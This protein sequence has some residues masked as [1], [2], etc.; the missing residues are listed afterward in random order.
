MEVTRLNFLKLMPQILE[1]IQSSTFVAYDMEH[2]GIYADKRLQNTAMDT[3]LHRYM[4][5]RES[6]RVLYPLQVGIVTFHN[7]GNRFEARPYSFYL[8]PRSKPNLERTFLIQSSSVEFLSGHNFD[9]NKTFRDGINYYNSYDR[10]VM[11]SK[12]TKEGV[13]TTHLMRANYLLIKDKIPETFEGDSFT[14]PIDF[15][16]WNQLRYIILELERERGLKATLDR[17][18]DKQELKVEIASQQSEEEDFSR[19]VMAL[20]KKPL[21]GHNSFM[22]ALHL[23]D[24]FVEPLPASLNT[25]R[26]RFVKSFPNFYDTKHII[27]LNSFLQNELSAH[28]NSSLQNCYSKLVELGERFNLPIETESKVEEAEHDAAYDAYSTGVLMIRS[29]QL[30]GIDPKEIPTCF[31]NYKNTIPLAGRRPSLTFSSESYTESREDIFAVM[32]IPITLSHEALQQQLSAVYG[33]VALYKIFWTSDTVYACPSSIESRNK[34]LEEV[35]GVLPFETSAG[36]VLV[37]PYKDFVD[38]ES[39]DFAA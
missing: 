3:L 12:Q 32:N 33:P 18:G 29:A 39:K 5:I 15:L 17:Q 36:R 35:K 9:F 25:F 37:C 24:K 26:Q 2:T 13:E 31:D 20:M 21:V 11:N 4:K 16:P 6:I 19:V 10:Y 27:L 34:M 7:H 23:Y 38:I 1:D 30:L 8:Y 28:R 22:D 14:L